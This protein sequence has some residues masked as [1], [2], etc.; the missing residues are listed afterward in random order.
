MIARRKKTFTLILEKIMADFQKKVFTSDFS[1]NKLEGRE[2][3]VKN[4]ETL[5]DRKCMFHRDQSEKK[6]TDS[7][8][9][10]EVQ[11]NIRNCLFG[12]SRKSSGYNNPV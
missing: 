9:I 6:T 7:L 1:Y 11:I 2:K 5:L 4:N 10:I 12:L 3:I 8:L